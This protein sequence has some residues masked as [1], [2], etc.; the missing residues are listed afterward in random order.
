MVAGGLMVRDADGFMAVRGQDSVDELHAAKTMAFAKV[1]SVE[2]FGHY[3]GL[4]DS[5]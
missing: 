5:N 1:G 3:V 2:T 4:Y